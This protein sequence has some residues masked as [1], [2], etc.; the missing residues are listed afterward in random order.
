MGPANRRY[1]LRVKAIDRTP[2]GCSVDGQVWLGP[3]I[4]GDV[5][6]VVAHEIGGDVREEGLALRV[7]DLRVLESRTRAEPGVMVTCTLGG[8]GA[9]RLMP[10]DVLLGE[11]ED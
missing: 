1:S 11:A 8:E 5:F 10:T 6:S 9:D 4:V 2:G 7:E 3:L